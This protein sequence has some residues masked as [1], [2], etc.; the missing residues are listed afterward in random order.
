MRRDSPDG[1]R[2]Q[3]SG[4]ADRSPGGLPPTPCA[5]RRKR[6]TAGGSRRRRLAFNAVPLP[7]EQ[8]DLLHQKWPKV[9]PKRIV[10]RRP[11]RQNWRTLA[12]ATGGLRMLVDSM[13]GQLLRPD[14][15]RAQ[16][17]APEV[18]SVM[19]HWT[20]GICVVTTEAERGAGRAGGNQYYLCFPGTGAGFLVRGQVVH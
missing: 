5:G 7:T 6:P 12:R 13:P 18:R 3:A 4:T 2:C 17:M 11:R 19:R 14:V 1:H 15:S 16:V 9:R 10:Q 8:G 20:S